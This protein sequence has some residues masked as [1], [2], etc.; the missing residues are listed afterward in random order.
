[1]LDEMLDQMVDANAILLIALNSPQKIVVVIC[2]PNSNVWV[3]L[4][5]HSFEKR[6][7]SDT[8]KFFC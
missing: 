8:L 1:M 4:F 2:V 7:L 5:S 3:R 6:K